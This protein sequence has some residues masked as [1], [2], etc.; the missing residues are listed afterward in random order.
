MS[1]YE[2]SSINEKIIK[3][4]DLEGILKERNI[5]EIRS[6]HNNI[7]YNSSGHKPSKPGDSGGLIA[8]VRDRQGE[9]KG[10]NASNRKFQSERDINYEG[11][12]ILEPG[13]ISDRVMEEIPLYLSDE[14][15]NQR[16]L[17]E[18]YSSLPEDLRETLGNGLLRTSGIE[19]TEYSV[20]MSVTK[21]N[22]EHPPEGRTGVLLKNGKPVTTSID[23]KEFVVE[24][25]GIGC[26]DG[27]NKRIEK[28]SR[29][30]YFGQSDKRYGSATKDEGERE[31]ENLEFQ[32]DR[33]S[34]TFNEGDAVR[35]AGLF[36]Y[37]NDLELRNGDLD[38][39]E[40]AYLIRLAPSNIRSSF[41]SNPAF[42][43]V[44]DRE[45]LLARTLGEHYS[46]LARLPGNLL[47]STIHPEN[48][49]WTGSRYVL[50]D[51]AD[52][53]RLDQID[54]PHNFLYRVL[55]KV[56]EVPGLS[57][58]G[59]NIFYRTVADGIGVEWDETTGYNGFIDSLWENYFA[60][61][62]YDLKRGNKS[63]ATKIIDSAKEYLVYTGYSNKSLPRLF[64]NS[65]KSHLEQEVDML[66]NI[67]GPEAKTSADIAKQRISYL[68]T[69]LE[70]GTDINEKFKED[71]ESYY[72]LHFLPYMNK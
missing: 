66:Q 28:M 38:D 13:W 42:P 7:R 62:V 52:C 1:E 57:E 67:D 4:Y 22:Y 23:G 49:L 34:T 12:F 68:E 35:A 72:S 64:I 3:T 9:I 41:N 10:I 56:N 65:A 47:H 55:N 30:G 48:I 43:K 61:R 8:V 71:P 15:V 32:R 45:T 31:L 11:M 25:K 37:S 14:K 26:P 53:R 40:Q 20:L 33:S 21:N 2:L 17:T 5:S 63:H 18:D 24:I 54:N 39:E 60:Q 46:E 51:F 6:P 16:I 19:S 36:L 50:T 27:N 70:D 58:E 69:Q 59:E 29:S 44:D